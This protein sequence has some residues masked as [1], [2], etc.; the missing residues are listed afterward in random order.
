MS[1]ETEALCEL[2]RQERERLGLGLREAARISG[3]DFGTLARV[4]RGRPPSF[5]NF[6]LIARWLKLDGF[7]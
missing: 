2:V 5:D 7:R 4:E 6:V 3:V 1:E